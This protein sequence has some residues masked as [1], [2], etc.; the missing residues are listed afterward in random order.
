[1]V[2]KN[3]TNKTLKNFTL[4]ALFGVFLIKLRENSNL[5]LYRLLFGQRSCMIN[6][7]FLLVVS[8]VV[9]IFALNLVGRVIAK[10]SENSNGNK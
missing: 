6:H 4:N 7:S 8:V 3:Y 9:V 1:V 2:L 5:L 10:K